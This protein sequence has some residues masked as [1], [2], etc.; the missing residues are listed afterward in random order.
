MAR[1]RKTSLELHQHSIWN[2]LDTSY[3]IESHNLVSLCEPTEVDGSLLWG[4]FVPEQPLTKASI[5]NKKT[6]S[7]S[8]FG[9]RV[10]AP[11]KPSI[12]KRLGIIL[13]KSCSACGF[14]SST[15]Q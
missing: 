6:R 11:P 8:C 2:S 15:A 1:T 3:L 13:S 5:Q 10:L 14:L 12:T 4:L 7:R 9:V